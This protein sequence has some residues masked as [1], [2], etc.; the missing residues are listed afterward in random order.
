MGFGLKDVFKSP[1][2][3]YEGGKDL[4]N[5]TLNLTLSP[6]GA[7]GNI[8]NPKNPKM[9]NVQEP[10]VMPTANDDE[11]RMARRR[12]IAAQMA[13]SGR[14]STIMSDKETLG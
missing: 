13:R 9:P 11:Q 12:A 6:F 8:L 14:A 2:K 4:Y 10:T 7:V 1:K 5:N 3:L